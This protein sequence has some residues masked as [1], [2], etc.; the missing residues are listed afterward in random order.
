MNSLSRTGLVAAMLAVGLSLWLPGGAAADTHR[1]YTQWSG[2]GNFASSVKNDVDADLNGDVY[3]ATSTGIYRFTAQ[4]QAL[5]RVVSP[6]GF[7]NGF[8]AVSVDGAGRIYA[9]DTESY[10]FGVFR[11]DGTQIAVFGALGL[12]AGT[13]LSPAGIAVGPDGRIY[14][15]DQALDNVQV[16]IW[17]PAI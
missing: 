15:T 4:G 5:G 9:V 6:A 13:F 12:G 10:R 14:V 2:I 16:S 3:V 8:E 17:R 7:T 1:F 11:P